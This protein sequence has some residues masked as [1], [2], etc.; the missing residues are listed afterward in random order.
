AVCFNLLDICSN[1]RK[2]KRGGTGKERMKENHNGTVNVTL[3]FSFSLPDQLLEDGWVYFRSSFYYVSSTNKT[4]QKSRDDCLSRG[5]DLTI[6]DSREEQDFLRR[7]SK[8]MW[9]G[10]TDDAQEGTWRWVDG[11]LVNT[12]YWFKGEPNNDYYGKEE[13]CAQLNN[14]VEGYGW[15]DGFCDFQHHWICEKKVAP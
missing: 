3:C 2:I 14:R 15:N 9:I 5:A 11:T 13:D 10:L 8:V 7:F 6:I 1:K 4:W 12:S